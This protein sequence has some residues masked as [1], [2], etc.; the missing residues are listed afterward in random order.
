MNKYIKIMKDFVEGRMSS[1][2]FYDL[3]ISTPGIQK[4]INKDRTDRYK[5]Y[6]FSPNNIESRF[7]RNSLFDQY[8]L[9]EFI[10][11]YFI[12]HKKK[13]DFKNEYDYIMSLIYKS[14]PS[15]LEINDEK[16]W[17]D[18]IDDLPNGI[19]KTKKIQMLKNIITAKF[20]YEKKPPKWVQ[21][22]EWPFNENRNPLHFMSQT[23]YGEL[24]EY[25]FLDP[26]TKQEVIVKQYF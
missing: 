12:R 2:E 20:T 5:N 9:Y 4:K 1:L 24:V 3:Y 18:L 10:R 23:T 21:A 11:A 13:Y 14:Q 16:F 26:I 22:P 25:L 19:S 6:Y 8:G 17:L 7:K 15:W